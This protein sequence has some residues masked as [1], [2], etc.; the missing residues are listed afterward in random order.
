MKIK[1]A[2]IKIPQDNPFR[3]DLL[4]RK[5]TVLALTSLLQN[6]DTP[7]TMSID[8]SWG[9]GKTT[10]LNMWKQHLDNKDF[11]VVSFNAWDTDFAEYPLIALTS[12]LL[13]TLRPLDD[14]NDLMLDD[15]EKTFP[16]LLKFALTKALPWTISLTGGVISIQA[17]DPSVD[18]AGNALAAAV[19]GTMDELVKEE[20]SD[21]KHDEITPEPPTYAEAKEA[22]NSFNNALAKT[23]EILSNKHGG[24]PLVIAI[25]ELDRCRPSYAVELLEVVKHFFT[26]NNVVFVLAIDKTQL[27]HAINAIYGS[28][29]D[30]IGY[31][32]R[33]IDLDVRLPDPEQT[34]F[35]DQALLNAGVL[36]NIDRFQ[37]DY[38]SLNSVIRGMLTAFLGA[39]PLSLRQIQ[40][41]TTRLG[42]ALASIEP[43]TPRSF[44]AFALITLLREIDSDIYYKFIRSEAT[45]KEVSDF[46]FG[47]PEISGLRRTS[48]G[49]SFEAILMLADEEFRKANLKVTTQDNPNLLEHYRLMAESETDT[50]LKSYAESVMQDFDK[51]RREHESASLT[52]RFGFRD[53]AKQIELFYS[54]LPDDFAYPQ[55]QTSRHPLRQPPPSGQRPF[56]VLTLPQRSGTIFSV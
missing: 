6:L 4:D 40:Q 7:Y 25:D 37:L 52:S 51:Y 24:R 17:N 9:N 29:F 48:M 28:N 49:I 22:I 10:F 44:P 23:A 55:S 50:S 26:V 27:A 12:E 35:V 41:A 14:N 1:P 31:L 2:D 16:R 47:L 21:Q 18:F 45:D 36:L 11:P 42:L 3:H 30:S 43:G 39:S 19:G 56:P 8:A 13:H 46:V 15:I 5:E 33:F 34:D 38:I 20:A 53:A 54:I 32:R